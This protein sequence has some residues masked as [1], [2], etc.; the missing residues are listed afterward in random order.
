M[1]V[2]CPG[3]EPDIGEDSVLNTIQENT[4]NLSEMEKYPLGFSMIASVS[5]LPR[6]VR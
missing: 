6:E 2:Y 3:Q 5:M 4:V 1:W